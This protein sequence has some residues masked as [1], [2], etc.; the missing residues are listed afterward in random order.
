M[1]I[2]RSIGISSAAKVNA[3]LYGVLGLVVAPFL[4]LGPGMAM[5]GESRAS[6]FGGIILFAVFLPLFY[7]ICG[8]IAGAVMAFLYNAI[9]RAIGGIEVELAMPLTASPVAS[10]PIIV[11]MPPSNVLPTSPEAPPQNPSEFE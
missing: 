5:V 2:I 9:A 8:F 11:S 7:A 1:T 4:L 6:G 3:L 10:S